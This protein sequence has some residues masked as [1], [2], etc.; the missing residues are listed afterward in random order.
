VDRPTGRLEGMAEAPDLRWYAVQALAKREMFAASQLEAQN[1]R[2]FLPY[3]MRTVRH[4]RR[5]RQ[6]KAAVF[7]GYL[8]VRLDLQRERWRSI[9]GTRG[10]V[11]IVS[12]PNEGPQPL[13]AGVIETLVDY[14]DDSGVCRLDRDLMVGQPV[15]VIAGP[16]AEALGTLARSD[17][18]GRVKVLLDLLGGQVYVSL[19]RSALEAA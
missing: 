8:F 3:L 14:V 4:A 5:V 7:P 19:N 13:P 18:K 17:D 6:I 10:V 2:I 12:M 11:R 15:R 1:F 16:L 9:N